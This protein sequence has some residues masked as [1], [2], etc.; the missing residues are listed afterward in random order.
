VVRRRLGARRSEGAR[1]GVDEALVAY[2]ADRDVRTLRELGGLVTRLSA[3]ADLLAV[4]LDLPLA[5]REL[6]GTAPLV[7]ATPRLG[8]RLADGA[9]DSFFLD[10]E[11]I[12]WDG[13]D[14][15]DRLPEEYR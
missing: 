11:K 14:L 6:E 2:L 5:R 9:I 8:V 15:A 1:D 12:A 10:A 7:A 4:P 3:T 13:T